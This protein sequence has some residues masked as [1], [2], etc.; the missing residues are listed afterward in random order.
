MAVAILFP[1]QGSQVPGM[2]E[3]VERLRPDLLEAA[4][5][6]LGEDP[7]ERADEGTHWA[8]PAIF[9]AA[10]AGWSRLATDV[11]PDVL[12]GHSLGE[13]PALVAAGALTD[14]DGLRL[15]AARGRLM[16]EAATAGPPAGMLAVLG[17]RG[18]FVP[19]L[20]RRHGLTVANDN[21][22]GQLVLSGERSALEHATAELEGERLRTRL[23]KVNGGFHSPAMEPAAGPFRAAL[24][25]V[26]FGEPALPVFSCVTAE[27]FRDVRDE[28]ARALTSPVR[29]R[30]V[31]LALR[32][33]GVSRC[34]ETGPGRV[35]TGLVRRTLEGVE[36]EALKPAEVV[37]A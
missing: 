16:H 31:L 20:A 30:E 22:P 15:V 11:R 13:I 26:D 33:R 25:A 29:W 32:A 37:N 6:E 35:L 23:L 7:F 27:P 28:L 9:C 36:A 5:R 34:I 10:L 19:E 17:D 1:G 14:A 24:D 3:Q 12:A 4:S 8:Q 21:A 2:R 18:S